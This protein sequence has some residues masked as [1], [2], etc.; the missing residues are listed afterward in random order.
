MSG[1][2]YRRCRQFSDYNLGLSSP[3]NFEAFNI[4]VP[5][6]PFEDRGA[7]LPADYQINGPVRQRG[8]SI[9]DAEF[10]QLLQQS[11]R[12]SHVCIS[13]R[14]ADRPDQRVPAGQ[15]RPSL[16]YQL[17]EQPGLRHLRQPDHGRHP[18]RPEPRSDHVPAW[19]DQDRRHHDQ[20][21]ARQVVV[22]AGHRLH[23]DPRVRAARVGGHR[24]VA[25]PRGGEVGDPGDRSVDRRT[26]DRSARAGCWHR[27]TRKATAPALSAGRRSSSRTSPPVRRSRKRPRCCVDT[28]RR[29][30]PRR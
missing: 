8:G 26:T 15:H 18:T 12:R 10:R 19:H 11:G 24:P 29:R 7:G 25:E 1:R 30:R 21:T 6:V 4:Y 28:S 9:R 14:A 17:P 13:H 2:R 5:W 23:L 3:T 22:H 20:H 16:H 27:T